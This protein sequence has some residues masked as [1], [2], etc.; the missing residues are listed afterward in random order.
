VKK[1]KGFRAMREYTEVIPRSGTSA[2]PKT[3]FF[4]FSRHAKA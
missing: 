1:M 2:H 4:S 3:P